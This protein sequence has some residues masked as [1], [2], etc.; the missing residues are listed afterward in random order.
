MAVQL[1]AGAMEDR[2]GP[3]KRRAKRVL[4]AE[5][6]TYSLAQAETMAVAVECLLLE[7]K[8][9]MTA[10]SEA[11]WRSRST[12]PVASSAGEPPPPSSPNTRTSRS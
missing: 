4:G 5:E 2:A 1:R 6:A 12:S 3:V 10:A 8:E 11:G 7:P 9:S